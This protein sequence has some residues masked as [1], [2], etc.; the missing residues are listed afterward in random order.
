[1]TSRNKTEGHYGG[2]LTHCP[3]GTR[4]K[5]STKTREPVK[6]VRK[7]HYRIIR[8]LSLKGIFERG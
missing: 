6:L 1:M 8:P 7:G 5:A 4:P 2:K 3:S